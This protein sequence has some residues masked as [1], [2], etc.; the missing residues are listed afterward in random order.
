M[1]KDIVVFGAGGLA[2]EV[3]VLIKDINKYV[4]QFNHIAFAVDDPYYMEGMFIHNIPVVNRTWLLNHKDSVC[5]VCTVGY[6]LVRARIQESLWEEGVN[7]VTIIHPLA[8][9][10]EGS[11]IGAGSV[12]QHHAAVSIDC[13]IGKGT[14]LSDYVNIG[15]DTH[16]GDYV[17]CFPKSQISGNVFI[18]N[19]A[20]IGSLSFINEKRKIGNEAVIAPG[21]MVFTNVPDG[22][23]VMGNPARRVEI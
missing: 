9:V 1:I 12:L 11:N 21:S 16:V 22:V 15:H 5:C 14:F 8:R 10:D 3:S 13:S 20:L 18:G 4:A 6:P 2:K 23:H 19:G 7:F 17:T